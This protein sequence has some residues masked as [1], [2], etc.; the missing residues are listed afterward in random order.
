MTNR[1]IFIILYTGIF[2]FFAIPYSIH[3]VNLA[4]VAAK[5]G[6]RESNEESRINNLKASLENDFNSKYPGENFVFEDLYRIQKATTYSD[7]TISFFI[8]SNTLKIK[9][10]DKRYLYCVSNKAAS[11]ADKSIAE[12]SLQIELKKLEK[13]YGNL[14][15]AMVSN[16]GKT[17]FF[18]NTKQVACED[19]FSN[20]N[21]YNFDALAFEDFERLLD[22]YKINEA[23]IQ[24]DNAVI[25]NQYQVQLDKIKSELT[26]KEQNLLIARLGDFYPVIDDYKRFNFTGNNLGSF[27]YTIP[28]RVIDQDRLNEA[29]NSIFSKRYQNYSLQNG[30]MPYSYCYGA[31]NSGPS[32][33]IVNAG[34]SD[35]LVSIKDMNDKVIRHAYVKSFHSF[36]LRVPNGNHQVFFYYGSGW[37]PK[38][39]MTHTIC[40]NLIGGFL[41]NEM[42]SKDPE[43][44]KLNYSY[45]EYSLSV[46]TGGNFRT[47]GSSKSEAF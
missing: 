41:N 24:Q 5:I 17:R 47:A 26:E 27:D 36:T 43:I 9:T 25:E 30:A 38:R 28:A 11:E 16:I 46:Q 21:S 19:F 1:L 6:F 37:N 33:V 42:I 20:N 22:E 32:R 15:N 12:K 14:V 23:Q 45:I 4:T 3:L 8:Y 44:I 39:S 2:L 31:K 18:K 34:N 35:V 13:E 29:L 40:G 10:I 7:T